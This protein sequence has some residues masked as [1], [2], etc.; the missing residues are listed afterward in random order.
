MSKSLDFMI[1]ILS[2]PVAVPCFFL[3]WAFYLRWQHANSF[4]LENGRRVKNGSW[5]WW[6]YRIML[7]YQPSPICP[8]CRKL[9]DSTYTT[10][11]C[12]CAFKLDTRGMK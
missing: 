1:A 10:D 9:I 12:D 4:T 5:A 11:L 7:S 3:M 8:D 6:W 2:A